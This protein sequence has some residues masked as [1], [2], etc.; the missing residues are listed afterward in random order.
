MGY[1]GRKTAV[2]Y[3]P[4]Q[5]PSDSCGFRGSAVEA[6]PVTPLDGH[7]FLEWF[8]VHQTLLG[9]AGILSLLLFVGT[10]AVVPTLIVALPTSYL[11]TQT[12]ANPLRGTP[13]HWPVMLVKNLLGGILLIAGIAMLILPGQGLLTIVIGLALVNFPG[14]K[15]LLRRTLGNR[16][17]LRTVNRIRIHAGRPPM[18]EPEGR[19]DANGGRGLEPGSPHEQ[20]GTQGRSG[21]NE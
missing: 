13:W 7:T 16:R 14:K 15:A 8:Q 6:F 9:W 1:T 12:G 21:G 18:E 2:R 20:R 3:T 17:V 19:K 11:T 4:P 5:R 10:L